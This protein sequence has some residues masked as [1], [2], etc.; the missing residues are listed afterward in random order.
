MKP[1]KP[2]KVLLK[3]TSIHD[4]L[5][6]IDRMATYDR[7]LSELSMTEFERFD[8]EDRALA[9]IGKPFTQ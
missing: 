2:L 6:S 5:N 8:E 9:S 3:L 7:M 1:S 4:L